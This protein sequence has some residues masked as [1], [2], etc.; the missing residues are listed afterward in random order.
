MPLDLGRTE[1][2]PNTIAGTSTP[3][4]KWRLIKDGPVYRRVRCGIRRTQRD[5]L[6]PFE[7]KQTST[8]SEPTFNDLYTTSERQRPD[9]SRPPVER[10]KR[11]VI[12][13]GSGKLGRHVVR[14]MVEHNWQ[15]IN[16]D[17]IPPPE[18]I[19]GSRW[20]KADLKDYGEVIAI[21]TEVDSLYRGI[22]AVIHL[23][24]IPAP[25]RAVSKLRHGEKGDAECSRITRCST[26]T[27]HRHITF[28]KLH[29]YAG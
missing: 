18:D 15:V 2:I 29:E 27:S 1:V 16:I 12:T 6:Y 10:K 22:D 7:V 17:F 26:T 25:G 4:P 11:V 9:P 28:S 13:G 8:M 19:P 3:P 14:E 21:L 24:A 5:C 23:A 20:F